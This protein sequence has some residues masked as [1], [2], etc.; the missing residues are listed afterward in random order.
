MINIVIPDNYIGLIHAV[1]TL[2]AYAEAYFYP[3]PPNSHIGER[4]QALSSTKHSISHKGDPQ[5]LTSVCL[6]VET[7]ENLDPLIPTMP[8]LDLMAKIQSCRSGRSSSEAL[9][10]ILILFLRES[11]LR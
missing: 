9:Q 7:S 11:N 2:I 6:K 3:K 8:P 10:M 1:I 5:A 4:P